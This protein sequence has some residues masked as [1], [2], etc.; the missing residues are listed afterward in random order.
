[1]E[2]RSFHLRRRVDDLVYEFDEIDKGAWK[3]RDASLWIRWENGLGWIARDPDTGAIAG[4][5][6]A[7]EAP[8]RPAEG[9]GVS[10]KGVRTYVYDLIWGDP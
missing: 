4:R 8:D 5:S 7:A 3:R 9:P 10:A 2:D 6:F 1:M